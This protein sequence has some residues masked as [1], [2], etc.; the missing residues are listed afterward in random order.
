MKHPLRSYAK[1]TLAQPF[2]IFVAG[3]LVA[4]GLMGV[5]SQ[6]Q[7]IRQQPDRRQQLRRARQAF[8]EG[9]GNISFFMLPMIM[10]GQRMRPQPSMTNTT[11]VWS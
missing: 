9:V 11:Q 5:A 3:P 1:L 8:G 6:Q 7:E 2:V 10:T 4:S